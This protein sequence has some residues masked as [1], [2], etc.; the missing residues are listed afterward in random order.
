MK[1]KL[2]GPKVSY[3]NILEVSLYMHPL[4][5]GEQKI[6]TPSNR[7]S[8]LLKQNGRGVTLVCRNF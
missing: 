2:A 3:I 6:S 8:S 5:I 4:R 7:I 1:N